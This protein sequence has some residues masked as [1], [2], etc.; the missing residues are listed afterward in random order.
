M[1]SAPGA[2]WIA[3]DR[4]GGG[5][6]ANGYP[7]RIIL[8]T[9]E[10]SS[11]PGVAAGHR[12]PPHLWYDPETRVL[13]QTVPFH[14][15][16]FALYSNGVTPTNKACALQ[17]EI[18]GR[19]QETPDWPAQWLDN[20]AEDVVVPMCRFVA[21]QG[22]SIDLFDVP[23]AGAIPGSASEHAPQRMT[24]ER[25]GGFRG[26]C[27]HRHVPL[28]DHWDPGGMDVVRIARHAALIIGGLLAQPVYEESTM[29]ICL[30]QAGLYLLCSPDRTFIV[31][32]QSDDTWEM[33]NSR[34]VGLAQAGLVPSL[35]DGSPLINRI[36]DDALSLLMDR[37]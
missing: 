34:L 24:L 9:I 31:L 2:I 7:F 1:E 5:T 10:G 19:A 37:T 21:S 23:E 27:G 12:A 17:V 16:A 32:N 6:Y 26:I 18:S 36:P 14:R 15:S 28:N 30:T 22:G 8:H 13:L 3:N 33:V 20:I 35:P 4:N 25:W 29:R 11:N